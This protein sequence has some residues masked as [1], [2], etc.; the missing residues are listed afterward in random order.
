MLNGPILLQDK[1][2]LYSL[3]DSFNLKRLALDQTLDQLTT[4][5]PYSYYSLLL[6]TTL[7]Y[8][9]LPYITLCYCILLYTVATVYTVYYSLARESQRVRVG[10]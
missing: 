2:I 8:T 7:Y 10:R 6:P 5:L 4:D 3:G 1:G 9:T